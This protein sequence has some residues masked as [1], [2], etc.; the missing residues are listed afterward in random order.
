MEFTLL[1]LRLLVVA[2]SLVFGLSSCLLRI[3]L[4]FFFG[5]VFE[6]KKKRVLEKNVDALFNAH[7]REKIFDNFACEKV[8]NKRAPEMWEKKHKKYFL[9]LSLSFFAIWQLPLDSQETERKLF[10]Y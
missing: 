1:P 4:F 2:L 10:L 3:E 9:F 6:E 8:R 7:K 5:R